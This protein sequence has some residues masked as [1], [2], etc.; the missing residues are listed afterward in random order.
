MGPGAIRLYEPMAKHTTMRVGGPAQFWVE[1]ETEQGFARLVKHCKAN[2]IPLMVIGRGSNLLVRDEG[3]RGLVVHLARGEFK[4][5]SAEHGL[6]TAGVG[7]KMKELS[8]AARD[9]HIG[10]FEWMEGIPGNVGGG[11]RMNAGAMGGEM[12]ENVVDVSY[13]DQDG[14]IR[15]APRVEFDVQYRGVPTLKMNYAVSATFRGYDSP[16][17]QIEHLIEE[18]MKKRRL[19]QPKESSAGCVFKNPPQCPAGKLLE[20]LGLKNLSVG[21]ARVSE[22]HCNFIVNDGGATASDVLALIEKIKAAA[23]RE[24]GIELETEVQ[25]IGETKGLHEHVD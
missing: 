19:V 4:R 15:T 11:L 1:P 14:T 23:R 8:N 22:V 12:F 3:I 10:G 16:R 24:R 18:A 20:E 5:L 17:E 7:V 25:I 2:Q 13:V 6:I 21:G 9:A